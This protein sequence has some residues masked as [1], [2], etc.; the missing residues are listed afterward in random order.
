MDLPPTR[1]TLTAVLNYTLHHL[2]VDEGI[3]YYNRY[4]EALSDLVLMVEPLHYPGTFTLKSLAWEGGAAIE[5]YRRE[6]ARL[7]IRLPG[8]L[9]PG[10]RLGLALNYEL[11]LPSPVPSVEV[12]PIPFGY[13]LRQTNLVD[14]FPFIP[15]YQPGSGWLAHDAG[16]FGEHLAYDLADFDVSLHILDEGD[17]VVAASAPAQAEGDWRRYQHEA[18]RSF[19]FSV[20]PEYRVYT[21]T[22]GTTTVLSYAFGF[23]EAA[24]QAVL[25]TTAEALRLYNQLYGAYPRKLISAVEADFLDGMEYDGMYFLSN[26]FYNLYQGTPGEYL[27]TIAAHETAHQWFYAQVGNDQALEPWLDEA[28]CTYSERLY[29]ERLHPLALDWWWQY[30]VNYYQPRGWVDG[31]IYNPEGYRAYRDAVYLNGAVFLEALRKQVGD[32]AFFAF[33]KDYVRQMSGKIATRGDFFR[34]LGEHT[35]ADLGPL[36]EAYFQGR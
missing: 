30:R 22:V 1:Y 25:D 29:F 15:P 3:E 33:L 13:T 14:W 18:A 23:H 8:P 35:E 27:V 11:S 21:A 4:P 24:G 6:G 26:G 9:E 12:R 36:L 2:V 17:L 10:E 34:I 32:G 7:R 19:A 16:F 20:S 28:L 5:D 31:S